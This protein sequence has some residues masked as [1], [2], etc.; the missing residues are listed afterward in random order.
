MAETLCWLAKRVHDNAV[1]HG[2]WKHGLAFGDRIALLHEA[3]T[4]LADTFDSLR[5]R[6]SAEEERADLLERL[7]RACTSSDDW[8]RQVRET[9]SRIATLEADLKDTVAAVYRLERERDEARAEL[10]RRD[11]WHPWPPTI[12]D[13]RRVR[14]ACRDG[15]EAPWEQCANANVS[16][17]HS[18]LVFCELGPAY[19]PEKGGRDG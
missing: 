3:L 19:V 18:L 12:R 6:Q 8:Q 16:V 14:V 7:D 17:E 11:E 10:R 5:D 15:Y 9:C 13:D 4:K 2:L 1:A